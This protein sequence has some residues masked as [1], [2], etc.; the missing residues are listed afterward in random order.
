MTSEIK[1]IPY[2]FLLTSSSHSSAIAEK[3]ELLVLK[4]FVAKWKLKQMIV[5]NAAK[6]RFYLKNIKKMKKIKKNE[7]SKLTLLNSVLF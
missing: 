3:E 4:R 7:K 6:T 2:F 5:K 1:C